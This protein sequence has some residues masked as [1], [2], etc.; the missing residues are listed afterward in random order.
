MD[1][2]QTKFFTIQT[3]SKKDVVVKI[4][5]L[6]H[7]TLKQA[8]WLE[9]SEA[10]NMRYLLRFLLAFVYYKLYGWHKA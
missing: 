9:E 5:I 1:E 6:K 2:F 10:R 7:R 8:K 4:K 3:I